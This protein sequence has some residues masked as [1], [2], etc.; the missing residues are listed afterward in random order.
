VT[1]FIGCRRRCRARAPFRRAS[2]PVRCD[3]RT[4]ALSPWTA[5][6]CA[7]PGAPR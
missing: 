7:V 3:C 6:P 4:P 1:Q 2:G 5:L